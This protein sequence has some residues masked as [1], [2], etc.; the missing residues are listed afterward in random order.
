MIGEFL[1]LS[2][3]K[4]FERNGSSGY[5]REELERWYRDDTVGAILIMKVGLF[6]EKPNYTIPQYIEEMGGNGDGT[7]MKK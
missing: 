1:A 7:T 6:V 5:G 2:N 4:E 3:A